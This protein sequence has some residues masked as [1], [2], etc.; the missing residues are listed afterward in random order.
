MIWTVAHIYFLIGFR[1]RAM[2]ALN[3]LW[4][5][6]R[7]SVA[8]A[9]SPARSVNLGL[10]SRSFPIW[11]LVSILHASASRPCRTA[12]LLARFLCAERQQWVAT[13]F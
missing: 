6:S 7:F 3:W 9:L 5:I 1:N 4:A 2:V 8:R 10:S 12:Q 11:S 13:K